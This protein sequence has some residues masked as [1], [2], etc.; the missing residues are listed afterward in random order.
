MDAVNCVT[1]LHVT[2]KHQWGKIQ[3]RIAFVFIWLESAT[4][5]VICPPPEQKRPDRT[6]LGV[7]VCIHHWYVCV[8]L[9][10]QVRNLISAPSAG[11]PSRCA[12]TSL[13]TWWCTLASG[14][15]SVPCAAS[16]SPRKARS[17]CTC[18]PTVLSAPS[19]ATCATGPSPIA[20]CW[21]ATPF[22]TLTTPPRAKARGVGPTWPHLPS[23]VLQVLGG[24]QVW[25]AQ[26]AWWAAWP[27]CP[28]TELPPPR[29][30]EGET[31]GG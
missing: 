9:L 14:P 12:T 7:S 28:A 23:T 4:T 20:P 19:S 6:A 11:A 10:L 3:K 27:T 13:N 21:S 18:A 24:P 25:L 17:T 29:A 1:L 8:F 26:L 5:D 22:S 16:A 31:G 15:S 30:R 2:Q